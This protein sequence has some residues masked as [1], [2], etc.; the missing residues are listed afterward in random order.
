M[1]T[2]LPSLMC[3]ING[4]KSLGSY[5]TGKGHEAW[6]KIL[7]WPGFSPPSEPGTRAF[8]PHPPAPWQACSSSL[9]SESFF[10]N[11]AFACAELLLPAGGATVSW[12][13][14]LP[15]SPVEASSLLFLLESDVF[16][17]QRTGDE[18]DLAAFFHQTAYPPVIVE[19]LKILRDNVMVS[20]ISS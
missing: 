11:S 16:Q 14:L 7:W 12:P 8:P 9:Q 19:L 6:W 2:L 3:V 20:F 13:A 18:A 5:E 10:L 1:G 17:L 4:V 15:D